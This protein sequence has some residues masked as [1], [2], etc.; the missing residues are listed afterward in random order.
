MRSSTDHPSLIVQAVSLFPCSGAF[1]GAGLCG[2]VGDYLGRRGTIALGAAIFC[3]GGA[4]Q[5]GAQSVAYLYSGRY[6][7]G[8][9]LVFLRNIE[10]WGLETKA[11]HYRAGVLTMIVPP[12][13]AEL[14]VLHRLEML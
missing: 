4:L 10:N 13:Q 11:W 9:A 3:L 1:F 14:Y 12:Y 5:T 6:F 2:P 7:A 8:F